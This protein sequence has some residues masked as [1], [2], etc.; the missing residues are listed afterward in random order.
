M[1]ERLV[2]LPPAIMRSV[3]G[4]RR[5]AAGV[6]NPSAGVFSNGTVG[7]A[8]VV[9]SLFVVSFPGTSTPSAGIL[10]G[11]RSFW[12]ITLSDMESYLLQI[13]RPTQPKTEPRSRQPSEKP[14]AEQSR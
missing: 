13:V 10:E 2:V 7:L 11:S 9:L 4:A 14:V 6:A 1:A 5:R 8:A 3:G 12:P